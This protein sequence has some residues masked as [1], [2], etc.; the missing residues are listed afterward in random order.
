MVHDT[1]CFAA[2]AA[3]NGLTSVVVAV[4][5]DRF[6]TMDSRA[7]LL[8]PYK[9]K[10]IGYGVVSEAI[11]NFVKAR[12]HTKGDDRWCY[13]GTSFARDQ[14]GAFVPGFMAKPNYPFEQDDKLVLESDNGNN[15]QLET[16]ILHITD[17]NDK[18][19]FDPREVP[20]GCHLVYAT[21]AATLVADVWTKVTTLTFLNY[22]FGTKKRYHIYG[23]A[24]W[25]ATTHAARLVFTGNSP[26]VGKRPGVMAGDTATPA[27]YAM[28]YGDFG[29]FEGGSLVQAE[30]IGSAGDTAQIFAFLIK[31]E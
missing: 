27:V 13:H 23:M 19:L 25:G 29:V 7:S 17:G 30:V 24:M 28:H 14:T 1:V 5:E 26:N 21:G 8:M 18:I 22:D 11:A 12:F 9:G 6:S 31:E 16:H 2:S 4:N 15:A 3:R 20:D 10:V